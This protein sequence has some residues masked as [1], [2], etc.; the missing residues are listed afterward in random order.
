LS[1]D[2]SPKPQAERFQ[3]ALDTAMGA[4]TIAQSAQSKDDW[5]LVVS[6]WQSAISLLKAVPKSSANYAIAQKKIADYQ[7]NLAYAQKQ[8]NSSSKPTG[9]VN[10]LSVASRQTR[11]LAP[12]SAAPKQTK[13]SA[14]APAAPKQTRPSTVTPEVALASHLKQIGAKFYGTYW[15]PYCTKQKDLFGAQ[16][17]RQIN[18]IECDEKGKNGRPDLCIQANITGFP[19][20]EIKGRLYSGLQSLQELADLSG[21]QGDRKFKS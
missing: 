10:S 2:S 17:F 13:P 1:P 3:E 16:A 11:P 18:Y 21:Y 5:N 20:W 12:A 14:P 7:R 19:T 15:C 9:T 6:R 8:Q 4:A